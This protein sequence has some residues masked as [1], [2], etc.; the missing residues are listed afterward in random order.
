[1]YAI[2][3]FMYL[4][5][6][7]GNGTGWDEI[8][9]S[10]SRPVPYM[11][12]GWKN[13]QVPSLYFFWD[14]N[15]SQFRPKRDGIL[16][17]EK[18]TFL[19]GNKTGWDE[20]CKSHSRPVYVIGIKKISL[21]SLNFFMRQKFVQIPSQMGWGPTESHPIRKNCHPYSWHNS[22]TPQFPVVA[23]SI[24]GLKTKKLIT[25]FLHFS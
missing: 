11:Q 8:Y 7:V 3:S 18:F 20:I 23:R 12:V 13:V 22:H 9:Q 17:L 15:M 19:I 5:T 1:M 6:R 16:Q 2:I 4:I 14:K 21:P 10:Q 24:Y 25:N